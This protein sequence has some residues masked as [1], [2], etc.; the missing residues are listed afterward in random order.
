MDKIYIDELECFGYHGVYEE[1][2]LRG[3]RFLI[4]AVIHLDSSEAASKDDCDFTVNYASVC[5]DIREIVSKGSLNLIEALAKKIAEDLM[6]KY[7]RMAGIEIRVDKPNAPM[8]CKFRSIAVSTDLRWHRVYIALGGNIGSPE[9]NIRGAIEE[10]REN[11]RF[12]G[13]RASSLRTTKPYGVKDQPDFINGAIEVNTLLSP[14]ELLT[15]TRSI[16][17]KFDRKRDQH[18]GPRTLDLDIIF[19]DNEI[20]DTKDLVIPHPEMH[21]RDFVLEPLCDLNP[22]LIHPV[23]RM[24]VSELL[25]NLR[26]KESYYRTC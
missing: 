6:F 2:K 9:G 17:D 4:S 1:E 7:N 24:S 14:G 22:N 18:W 20:I 16:E 12:R 10:L 5:Q 19:Y 15:L 8:D 25:D 23:Y 13:L 26:K 3:Q 11:K 21:K